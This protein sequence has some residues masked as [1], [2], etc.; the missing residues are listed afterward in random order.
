MQIAFISND[1]RADAAEW[2]NNYGVGPFYELTHIPVVNTRYRGTPTSMD[3]SAAIAYWGDL[4]VEFIQQFDDKPSAYKEGCLNQQMGVHHIG[5]HVEDYDI[6]F[7]QMRELNAVPVTETEIPGA[8]RATYF[9]VPGR[10]P[11]VEIIEVQPQFRAD[12]DVMK[13]A[14]AAWNGE[15]PY[16]VSA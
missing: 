5:V 10:L 16:R 6:A 12:W 1:L 4:Q 7:A 14:A 9:E 3:I 2:S 11:F 8:V 15:D 13:Q